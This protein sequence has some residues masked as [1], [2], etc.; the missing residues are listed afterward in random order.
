V[1]DTDGFRYPSAGQIRADM[2]AIAQMGANTIRLY[3]RPT[4][5]LVQVAAEHGLRLLLDLNWP[6]H[7]DVYRNKEL[8][9]KSFDMASRA[10]KE[11]A[12]WQNIA[13]VL[14]GNEI[15]ADLVRW[16]GAAAIEDFI[17]EMYENCRREAPDVC[18]GFANYPTTEYLQFDFLDFV[19]FNVYLDEPETFRN[20]M[21]RLRHLYPHIPVLLSECGVDTKSISGADDGALGSCLRHAF[22][23]GIAGSYVFAWTDE[24]HTGGYDINQ[25]AFGLVDKDRNPKPALEQVAEIFNCAPHCSSLPPERVSVVVATYNG[26]RTLRNCLVSLEQLHYPDYEVI[27]VNDG[28]TD[29][30]AV[31]LGDFPEVR[32][33]TQT[34][35]GLSAARNSGIEA[36][37]GSIV[38]F[39][40]SDCVADRDWLY[41]LVNYMNM[42][43]V[44]GVGGPNLTPASDKL[45]HQAVALAPGHATHVLLSHDE[46]EHVPG[47]N[48]AFRRNA[49]VR[50][51]GFDPLFRK[52]GDD[53][54]VI[55]R[56]QDAGLRIGF[57]TAAFVWHYRRP[58][59]EAYLKQQRGYGEAD[60]L[61]MRKHPHRFN[62]RGQSIW[63][64]V[65]YPSAEV[66]PLFGRR[67]VRYGVFAAA[68]YQCVYERFAGTW[69]FYLTSLEWWLACL[70]L[71]AA[72][73]WVPLGWQLAFAGALLSLSVSAIRSA[74]NWPIGG[75]SVPKMAFP[76]IWLLWVVQPVARG[77]AR[78]YH[79]LRTSRSMGIAPT[80]RPAHR[81]HNWPRVLEYWSEEGTWRVWV[82][83]EIAA[84]MAS[85]NWLY[86][87]N[88]DW[89]AWDLSVPVS[90]WFKV[91]VVTAEENNG[92]T[93]QMLRVR[94][95]IV[96]TSLLLLAATVGISSVLLVSMQDFELGRWWGAA[97]L[98]VFWLMYRRANVGL[99]KVQELVEEVARGTGGYLR[100]R[101]KCRRVAV[102]RRQAD[103]VAAAA[104]QPISSREAL[105]K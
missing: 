68:G 75:R 30:T 14:L 42:H 80:P 25:W 96:P 45:T 62:E 72:G 78:Y 3:D 37:T 28:S 12:G 22:E 90:W 91:R 85:Q 57:S 34:N 31:I 26:G 4:E 18:L 88:N 10:M 86:S 17:F 39:T 2:A 102:D 48:M 92:G 100:V 89:E 50:V 93:K 54:D 67:A 51:G 65:I 35:L 43:G 84:R 73:A 41:N 38:A 56:M 64:G 82:L 103:V 58:T 79:W 104:A 59:M 40:D 20:Y 9:A 55:W 6:K 23:S 24:W 53:V 97:L 27:V 94:F 47:C 33:I 21:V 77:G 5:L 87:H 44:D 69:P 49:L 61:V 63:R 1:P 46:A 81:G 60:A 66:R 76:L 13:G 101:R 36:A 15:P 83:N 95:S 74:Q 19:G 8:R 70:V 11:Y 71:A 52:A 99:G 32:V 16:N 98:L 105:G 29:D 7:L